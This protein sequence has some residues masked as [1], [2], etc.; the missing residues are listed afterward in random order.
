MIQLKLLTMLLAAVLALPTGTDV[1]YQLGGARSV[2]GN[3]GIV[4]RDRH[5]PPVA[6]RYDVCYV[7]GFQTQP[8]ELAFWRARPRLVLRR[9]GHPVTD[10]AWGEW[11]LDTRTTAKRARLARII[12]RWIDGCARS[13]FEAVEFDNLDSWSRSGNLIRP[14]ANRALAR[15]LV[16]RAHRAGLAAGQKNWADWNG[17]R[18]GYDFAIAEECGRYDE[19]GSYVSHYGDRVLVI[20]YRDQDFRRTC[21]R[22][23]ARLAVVR[24]DRALSPTGVR[25]F[26]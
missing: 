9:N 8:D 10:S 20:E 26:C 15:L 24:R 14:A 3:V 7:N 23:G 17:R 4:V 25:R 16:A 18:V 22:W 21:A 5:D 13:G 11:L 6:G 12:G 19:C 2:P 1:D